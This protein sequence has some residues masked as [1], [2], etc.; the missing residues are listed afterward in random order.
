MREASADMGKGNA[1]V[2]SDLVPNVERIPFPAYR[3]S[4]PYI[5]ISYAHLD[6]DIVFPEIERFRHAGYNVWYDEEISPGNGWANDIAGAISGC[7]LF[8]VMITPQ[9]AL[10]QNIQ[11]EIYYALD[12]GIPFLAIHLQKTELPDGLRLRTGSM[13]AILKYAMTDEKYVRQCTDTFAR[14]GIEPNEKR[15]GDVGPGPGSD[16]DVSGGGDGNGGGSS[17]SGG[18]GSGGGGDNTID[19][20]H[21][22]RQLLNAV[23]GRPVVIAVIV[24]LIIVIG[25]IIG[26]K[27][28]PGGSSGDGGSSETALA[29]SEPTP[30][31][32]FEIDKDGNLARFT[33]DA[34]HVVI[35]DSVKLI[36]DHAFE[37]TDIR[38]VVVPDSVTTIEAGAF[39][40]CK[41]LEELYLSDG[42]TEL[43][44]GIC[45]G[46]VSLST[47]RLPNGLT[48]ISG[49]DFTGCASLRSVSIPDSVNE[50]DGYAFSDSG[51]ESVDL[52]RGVGTIRYGAFE[53][54]HLIDRVRLPASVRKLEERAFMN[55]S[56]LTEITL[57]EG[58]A[59][60]DYYAFNGCPLTEIE[61][62]ASVTSI[63]EDAFY[64]CGATLLVHAGSYAEAFAKGQKLDHR[65]I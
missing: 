27:Q 33:G 10:R 2:R 61:I 47:V 4:D 3:E 23:F 20:A 35:P 13:Q 28:P 18:S 22:V 58:L 43:C 40:N 62:P 36:E 12:E 26:T 44:G 1:T 53:D 9:S 8:V 60:I 50:I 52:G 65:V 17:A 24:V 30:L 46:C 29:E 32:Q 54:C 41:L 63:D 25:I 7:A 19:L 11:D 55:C 5:F 34:T 37:G 21:I 14:N 6:K 48:R 57:D 59:S 51:L 16:G 64:G 49:S 42:V 39:A 45:E 15:G 31:D 56:A 38:S